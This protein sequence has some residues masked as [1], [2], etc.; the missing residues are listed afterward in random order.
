MYDGVPIW[1]CTTISDCE[2]SDCIEAHAAKKKK[3][4]ERKN[5]PDQ[6]MYRLIWVL[7]SAT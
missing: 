5:N 2:I 4:L 7:K 1:P 3:V 6:S